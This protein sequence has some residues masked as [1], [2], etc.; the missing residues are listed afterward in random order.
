MKHSDCIIYHSG[1]AQG[2]SQIQ[3]EKKK[4]KN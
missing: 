2:L 1:Q 4:K 3:G